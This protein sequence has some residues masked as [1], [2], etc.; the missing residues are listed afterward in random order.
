M[1][2]KMQLPGLNH[3]GVIVRN[4]DDSLRFYESAFGLTPSQRWDVQMDGTFR[5][6]PATFSARI[7]YLQMGTAS[8]ELIEP[9]GG[10]ST[11]AEFLANRGEG[12][13][14]IGFYIPDFEQALAEAAAQGLG[15]LQMARFDGGGF[16]YFDTKRADGVVFEVVQLPGQ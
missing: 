3:V 14:H 2:G 6:Q 15:L 13:H 7:A 11:W 9:V 16:A 5:G 8:L 4:L 1:P 12:M 10:D